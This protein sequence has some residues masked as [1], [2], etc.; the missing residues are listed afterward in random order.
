MTESGAQILYEDLKLAILNS[1][2]CISVQD[3]K[4]IEAAGINRRVAV[5]RPMERQNMAK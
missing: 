5:Y 1:A 2:A 4:N 3:M